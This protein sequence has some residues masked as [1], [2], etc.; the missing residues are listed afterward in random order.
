MLFLNTRSLFQCFKFSPP[1]VSHFDQNCQLLFFLSKYFQRLSGGNL[2]HIQCFC[3]FNFTN[4][5]TEPQH[6]GLT[7]VSRVNP[8]NTKSMEKETHLWFLSF[9]VLSKVEW[10][11]PGA[12]SLFPFLQFYQPRHQT[13]TLW[14]N[15]GVRSESG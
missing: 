7:S 4:P 14:V 9:K 5:D 8:G 11:K 13:P 3:F 1:D 6:F 15:L 12:Y 10:R 2:E